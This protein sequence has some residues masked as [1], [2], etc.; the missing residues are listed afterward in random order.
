MKAD[1][2]RP[3]LDTPVLFITFNRPDTTRQV[4]NAIREA[5]PK[6]LFIAADGPREN[7]PGEKEKCQE[8]RSLVNNIDWDCEVKTLFGEKNLGCGKGPAAAI[9]WFFSNVEEGII[10]EDDCLP[11]QDFFRFCSELL[12]KYRDDTRV[13]QI[14][15]NNLNP[16]PERDEEYSYF[17][18]N[19][20]YIWGWATWRRAWKLFNFN[21]NYYEEVKKNG[22]HDNYFK[23]LDEQVYFRYVFDQTYSNLA[24]ATVWDYQWQFS[25]MLQAGLSVVPYR[26]LVVNMG[27]GTDA[28]H[29]TKHNEILPNLKLERLTFPLRHPEFVMPNLVTD[30]KIFVKVFTTPWWRIRQR[31]KKVLPGFVVNQLK[32]LRFK[33]T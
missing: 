33:L 8:V 18:S 4:F 31:L 7:R 6:K 23:S 5:R 22:Y 28:T 1:N 17:F 24:R 32:S 29:T 9:T 21:M 11:S 25:R 12:E 14:G 20:N 13:M 27:Y 30:Q 2:E 3:G 26:N 19:H 10:L 16:W 15:G